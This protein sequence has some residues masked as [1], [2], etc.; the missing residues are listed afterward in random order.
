MRRY[1]LI[2]VL[3]FIFVSLSSPLFAQSSD[4]P[5]F[6]N[7]GVLDISSTIVKS[8]EVKGNKTISITIIF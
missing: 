2:L 8:I 3:I 6:S 4:G 1:I 5:S 7:E